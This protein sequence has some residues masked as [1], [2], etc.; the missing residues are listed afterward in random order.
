MRE[1]AKQVTS[2]LEVVCPLCVV[3]RDGQPT[4]VGISSGPA[5]AFIRLVFP[6]GTDHPLDPWSMRG[7]K[8]RAIC[9]QDRPSHP[10]LHVAAIPP[11]SVDP[12]SIGPLSKTLLFAVFCRTISSPQQ[13]FNG[14]AI[15][16]SIRLDRILQSR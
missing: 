6:P 12:Y 8:V 16:F 7:L 15:S 2:L 13:E 11:S 1:T 10:P 9:G 14:G 5:A 4:P 3:M